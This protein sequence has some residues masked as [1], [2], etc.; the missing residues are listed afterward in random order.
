[1]TPI[2]DFIAAELCRSFYWNVAR[3]NL[4]LRS[5]ADE[6][7]SELRVVALEKL[8]RSHPNPE[9]WLVLTLKRLCWQQNRRRSRELLSLAGGDVARDSASMEAEATFAEVEQHAVERASLPDLRALKRDERTALQELIAGFSYKEIAG[10]HGWTY[11]KV[12]RCISEGR[13]ALRARKG[14]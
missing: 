6:M 1:M 11:T 10:R 14:Y 13:A 5:D 7:I 3:C 9:G 8:P 2:S 4:R 12:N